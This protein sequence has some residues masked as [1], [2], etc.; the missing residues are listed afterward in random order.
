MPFFLIF[1]GIWISLYHI[2]TTIIGYGIFN[3][4]IIQIIALIKEAIRII[5]ISIF[6]L[7]KIKN[8]KSYFQTRKRPRIALLGMILFAIS[9]S[10]LQDKSI[11]NIFVWLK[12]NFHFIIIFLT[13]SIIWYFLPKILTNRHS[14]KVI[15]I[16]QYSLIFIVITGFI[17][18]I[19][20]FINPVFFQKIGYGPIGDFIFWQNPPIYYRTGPWGSPRRQGIFAW[21]NN[22]GYFLTA[23][24]PLIIF[25]RKPKF[26][27][28]KEQI[29]NNPQKI[30]H[31]SFI[32]IWISTIILTLSRAAIIGGIVAIIAIYKNELKK[33]KKIAITI[34]ILTILTIGWLSIFK[35]GSTLEHINSKLNGIISV[36][37]NPIW[38]FGLG[39]AWPAIHHG[40][41]ILPENYYL[42]VIIDIWTFGFLLRTILRI[43][44]IKIHKK[45]YLFFK[46]NKSNE[47]Q[48]LAYL[49]R[50]YLNIGFMC[51]LILWFFLHVFEDS[52]VNFLFFVPFGIL[53][54]YLS[55]QITTQEKN[56]IS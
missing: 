40:W 36:N 18:Q 48:Q 52:M 9:T 54:G 45:I 6:F 35:W 23:F 46:T 10:L 34:W 21:P 27:K 28:I 26:K 7:I 31:L 25:R 47:N 20:K 19:C 4:E 44:I 49:H 33:N 3:G 38:G 13:S 32:V 11:Y 29:Y 51:L 37:N 5:A 12:Y 53:S 24:F 55:K 50:N 56:K 41:N 22:Y 17:R 42:Q 1:F 39:T 15:N 8:R 2:I 16:L 43:N 14:K 30:L